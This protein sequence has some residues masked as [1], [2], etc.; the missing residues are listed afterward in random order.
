MRSV[1]AV[2]SIVDT[3]LI[4][5][6]FVRNNKLETA[7]LLPGLDAITPT[8]VA[9]KLSDDLFRVI[10]LIVHVSIEREG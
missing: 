5:F 10:A 2:A 9:T 4:R 8:R 7:L 6:S 3:I 1:L